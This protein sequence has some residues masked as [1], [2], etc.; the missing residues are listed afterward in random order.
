VVVPTPQPAIP[1]DPPSNQAN[2]RIV[3]QTGD[4]IGGDTGVANVEDAAMAADGT[5][6]VIVSVAN[7]GGARAVARRSPGGR[8]AV[9]FGEGNASPDIDL[10]TLV[11]LRMAPSG[12]MVF[13]SGEG[14]DVERFFFVDE[15]SITT[16]AGAP[17]GVVAPD[18]RV[19]GNNRIGP[20]GVVAFV[21]GGHACEDSISPGGSL[22]HVCRISLYVAGDGAIERIGTGDLDLAEVATNS[23]RV[24]LDPAGNAYF[25]VPGRREEPT[26]IRFADGEATALLTANLE[27]PGLG[28]PLGDVEAVDIAPG[29]QIL[30]SGA[31]RPRVE[32][33]PRPGIV[34]ILENGVFSPIAV[35]GEAIGDETVQSLRAIAIDG[36]GN[37]LYE[38]QFADP[39]GA[40]DTLQRSLRLAGSA[41][42][43]EIV[44][45]GR[46]AP[47]GGGATVVSIDA[48]RGNEAGDVVFLTSLGRITDG[49]TFIEEIRA[50][51]R[52]ADGT[53]QTLASSARSVQFGTI[54]RMLIVG[55][56]E[57]A[58]VLLLAERG[59]SSDRALLLSQ[60]D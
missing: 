31:L 35:E 46:P 22:R 25:S 4:L 50:T 17:P 47:D 29:E 20:N 24:E 36:A 3:L 57:Q 2:T 44:R 21:A 28:E 55:L 41:G 7:R 18:F 60:A 51:L 49:T 9:V 58:N 37:A 12:E 56:D 5:L 11:R 30:L 26:L 15:D 40:S 45:E 23:I 33:G 52:R 16:L 19:L 10:R 6:A 48:A 54:S 42:D 32:G 59:Q 43:V 53:L 34:G 14:L 8:F 27:I 39:T 1:V 38:A 13:Q